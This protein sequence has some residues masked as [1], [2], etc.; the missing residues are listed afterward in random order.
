M[1]SRGL[2]EPSRPCSLYVLSMQLTCP[3]SEAQNTRGRR[4]YRPED[5]SLDFGLLTCN[6]LPVVP[7]FPIYS[8]SGEVMVEAVLAPK[9]I[10]MKEEDAVM[11]I[12]FHKFVFSSVLRLEKD[13][14]QFDPK[15]VGAGGRLHAIYLRVF[16]FK[17][18]WVM[19]LFRLLIILSPL[20]VLL[21]H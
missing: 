17:R 7:G 9:E 19:V 6:Q 1:L 18:A 16:N 15:K 2:P 21:L 14:M 13:P 4:I 11:I 3:I 5:T 10:E 8:R 12:N 20:R